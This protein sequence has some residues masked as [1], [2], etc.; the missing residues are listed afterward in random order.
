[1]GRCCLYFFISYINPYYNAGFIY[2]YL[3]YFLSLFSLVIESSSEHRTA[4]YTPVKIDIAIE[5]IAV[6][7]VIA[8][9]TPKIKKY[10]G[11]PIFSPGPNLHT[12]IYVYNT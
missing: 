12:G 10:P 6:V 5:A 3:R 11:W 9:I 7:T 2:K 1:M 4:R 8:V